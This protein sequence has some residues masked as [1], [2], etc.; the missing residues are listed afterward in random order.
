MLYIHITYYI[1][2]LFN[3]TYYQV[4]TQTGDDNMDIEIQTD[5]VHN[6]NKWTQFPVT[7]RKELHDKRDIDL[8]KMV[9]IYPLLFREFD[10]FNKTKLLS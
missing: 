2:Y 4:F 9:I 10:K 8:F 7:C 3:V 1:S 6:K 5:E